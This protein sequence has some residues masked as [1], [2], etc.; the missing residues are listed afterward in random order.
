MPNQSRVVF[1]KD[2]DDID[3]AVQKWVNVEEYK[4][5]YTSSV[6]QQSLHSLRVSD[7]YTTSACTELGKFKHVIIFEK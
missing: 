2:Q 3:H 5:V 4:R 7:D 1:C 6:D